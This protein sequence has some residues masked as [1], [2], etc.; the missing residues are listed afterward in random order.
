MYGRLISGWLLL[1]LLTPQA[2]TA[3]DGGS[4]G[5]PNRVTI[6]RR[7]IRQDL[8]AWVV[9]YRLRNETAAGLVVVPSEIEVKTE[10]WVSN[11]RLAGHSTPRRAVVALRPAEKAWAEA[12]VIASEDEA[13]RCRERVS[14]AVWS[15]DL[16]PD[17]TA[18]PADRLAPIS[19]APGATGLVRLRFDHQH[20]VQG[21][22]DPLL[23]ARTVA[24]RVGQETF[25]DEPPLDVEARVAEPDVSWPEPPVERRDSRY[26][27][28]AP[29]SLHLQ[30][31]VPGRQYFRYPDRPVRHGARMR[32][33][34]WYLVAHGGSGEA[35]ARLSQ[36]KDTPTSCR[37]IPDGGLDRELTTVGRWTH[38][39]TFVRIAP[40]ATVA[41]L[42]FRLSSDSGIGE[43][44]IDDVAFEPVDLDAL[45]RTP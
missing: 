4:I 1:G 2:T 20:V 15:D 27:V 41:A 37:V 11:S 28:S 31:D 22:C 12:D 45:A 40:E 25:R 10:G 29:D 8:G 39:E 44:W 14:L 35:R 34:F 38:V 13:E 33:T 17:P 7:S 18:R 3:D 32:L 24:F 19:L 43:M 16:A 9:D 21:A 23:G 30:A 6:V 26:Y 36:Y 42:E 5:A